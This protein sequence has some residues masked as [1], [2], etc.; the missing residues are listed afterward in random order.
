MPS[1]TQMPSAIIALINLYNDSLFNSY[2]G[3]NSTP[4]NS[5]IVQPIT[6]DMWFAPVLYLPFRGPNVG[7]FQVQGLISDQRRI[8]LR[9]KSLALRSYEGGFLVPRHDPQAVAQK[10]TDQVMIDQLFAATAVPNLRLF[11]VALMLLTLIKY[12]VGI[13]DSSIPPPS[14][15]HDLDFP[16]KLHSN[17]LIPPPDA[18]GFDA[19]WPYS[20]S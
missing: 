10:A 7:N 13:A 11:F 8:S 5:D 4:A 18:R 20:K 3:G 15:K 16:I 19:A 1:F 14:S 12:A 6:M 9:R 2:S 17:V